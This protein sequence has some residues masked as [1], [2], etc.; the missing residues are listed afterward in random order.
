MNELREILRESVNRLFTDLVT[1]ECLTG[2]ENGEW[3]V[4]GRGRKACMEAW[5][6]LVALRRQLA[7]ALEKPEYADHPLN[8]D[9]APIEEK[10]FKVRD[11]ARMARR[12]PPRRSGSDSGTPA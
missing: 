3:P 10:A 4:D 11:F 9:D 1:R 8:Q 12:S 6:S 5:V 7:N 2:A